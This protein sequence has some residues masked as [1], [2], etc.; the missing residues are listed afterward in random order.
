MAKRGIGVMT[1]QSDSGDGAIVDFSG[2]GVLK[3]SM[4]I[5]AFCVIFVV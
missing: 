4:L 5:K 3:I 2:G 1:G